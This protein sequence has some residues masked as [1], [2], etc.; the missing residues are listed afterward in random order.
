MGFGDD[1]REKRELRRKRRIRNQIMA[2]TVLIV[3]ILASAAGIVYGVNFLRR[4]QQEESQEQSEQENQEM[5]DD[6]LGSEEAIATPEPTPE[7]TPEV[8]GPTPEELLDEMIDAKIA[9][10]SLEDKVAGLFIV[11]P[12]A[13]T[14]V[15]TVVQAGDGT[16]QALERYPVGGLIYFK[17]NIKSEEQLKTMLENTVQYAKYPLFL[18]VDEEGGTLVSRILSAGLGPAVDSAEA[19]G[20]GGDPQ[21]AYQAGL[22]IGSTLAGLGFNLDFAPV[23]DVAN[24]ENSVMKER[25]F[26]SDAVLV[27]EFVTSMSR[28]IEESG[29]SSCLKHFPGLGCTTEDTHDGIVSTDRTLEQFTGEEFVVFQAGI[30]AGADMIMVGHA[31][32]PEV[33]GDN[34]PCTF[35]R[36]LVT[37]I[38]REQMNYDGVVITDALNM[39]AIS[40]YYGAGEAACRALLAGCDMLLMPED[41]KAALEGVIEAVQNGNIDEQRINDSL[42]RVYRI[43]YADMMETLSEGE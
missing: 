39:T 6:M 5:I 8:T 35:S 16:R 42:R 32:A 22:T 2:Y 17:K 36:T 13:I 21:A 24:V 41:F 26:G 43:K 3:L 11:T 23:A 9:E 4:E 29:V 37:D 12:E 34:L 30:D 28:G 15:S 27:A 25:S 10:M 20:A 1:K 19:I 7:P 18:A 38:L 40:E 31:L 14:G 33:T